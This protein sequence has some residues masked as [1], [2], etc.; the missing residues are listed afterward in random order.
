MIVERFGDD[1]S[2]REIDDLPPGY[3]GCIY[4]YAASKTC[5]FFEI[6]D[7]HFIRVNGHLREV[8]CLKKQ[9]GKFALSCRAITEVEA[10]DLIRQFATY[11]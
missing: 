5:V 6:G 7:T 8:S 1:K 9:V 11:N 3:K 2:R 10:R 4:C